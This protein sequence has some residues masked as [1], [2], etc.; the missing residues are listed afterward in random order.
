MTYPRLVLELPAW[1]SEVVAGHC[2]D[3]VRPL[4]D[5]EDRMRLAIALSR[6]SAETGGGPFGAAVFEVESRRL[7]APGVNLVVPAGTSIAHAEL[8]ALALAQRIVGSFDLAADPAR[9]FELVTS[10][11]PCAQCF[12]ALPWSGIRHLVCGA[13]TREAEAIGFDEGPKPKDWV[14]ALEKRG[15]HVRRGV[16]GDEAKE[17]LEAY[18]KAGGAIYNSSPER[19]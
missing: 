18:A 3:P 13:G 7:V 14:E 9:T 5:I 11:E 17:I 15:I 6:R 16:L 1:V 10:T 12:G 19:E 4:P 2:G 8:V